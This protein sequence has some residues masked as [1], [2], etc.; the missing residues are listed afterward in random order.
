MG[1]LRGLAGHVLPCGCLIGVYETY[2][3]QVQATIDARSSSCTVLGHR[4]YARV[5]SSTDLR[6]PTGP[7]ASARESANNR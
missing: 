2:R 7:I 5:E 1:I 4:L 3:G 6:P